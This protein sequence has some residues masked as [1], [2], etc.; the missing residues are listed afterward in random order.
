MN[1][2]WKQ[3][4]LVFCVQCMVAL[5][6]YWVSGN[7]KNSFYI[8]AGVPILLHFFFGITNGIAAA[9][10][11]VSVIVG[12]LFGSSLNII[13]FLAV[14]FG[15]IVGVSAITAA[16]AIEARRD[17]E[18]EDKLFWLWLVA[19]PAGIG[20]VTGGLVLFCRFCR[21]CRQALSEPPEYMR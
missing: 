6:V 9:S 15:G 16:T 18:T 21:S 4:T 13:A 5:V 20:T 14:V 12:S 2:I 1:E 11:L 8:A 19:M 7:V 17:G 10:A 3:S